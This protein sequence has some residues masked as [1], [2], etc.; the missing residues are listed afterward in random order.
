MNKNIDK[1]VILK[2]IAPCAFCCFTCAAMKDGIIEKSSKQL[3]YYLEGYY[4][5]NR[6][7]LPLRYRGFSKRLKA[8]NRELEKMSDRPCLGCRAGAD[9]RC[10]IPDCF[11]LEC[12]KTHKV[13]FCGQCAE[14]P[15]S[16]AMDFFKGKNLE[17]WIKNNNRIRES[18]AE[19]YYAFAV[20]KSHYH[21]FAE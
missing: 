16:R 7:N 17:Q 1:D 2:A 21:F 20:S 6:I 13:D 11:I 19:E 18:S 9:K 8:L 12:A 4:E 10:C 3:L 15:C 14:F 5:F